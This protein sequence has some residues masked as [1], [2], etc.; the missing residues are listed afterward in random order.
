MSINGGYDNGYRSCDCFWGN[1]PSSLV[2]ALTPHI[3]EFSGLRVLDAGCGEGKNAAFLSKQG[4]VVTAVDLSAIAIS[5]AKR[6][7]KTLAG[8]DWVQADIRTFDLGAQPHDV[9][10]AYLSVPYCFE[11][12][13][14]IAELH[15]SLSRVTRPGGYH[16]VCCFNSRKQELDAAHPG[17]RPCLVEHGFYCGRMT[18]GRYSRNRMPISLDPR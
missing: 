2:K 4:A 1:E 7:W 18:G 5:H 3:H 16:A 14:E 12:P 8:V 6:D 13:V 17:F 9:V 11:S 15:S 10:I